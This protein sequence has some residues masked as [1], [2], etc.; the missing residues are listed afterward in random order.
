MHGGR[1][2]WE[3]MGSMGSTPQKQ[4]KRAPPTKRYV[5][6]VGVPTFS[7]S[8][9]FDLPMGIAKNVNDM[10]EHKR[11]RP[12]AG[13]IHGGKLKSEYKVLQ[14]NIAEE[15][16]QHPVICSSHSSGNA[17]EGCED[18]QQDSV[19]SSRRAAAWRR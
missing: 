13:L 11:V 2:Q 10:I 19:D 6:D 16:S 9:S 3:A 12:R 8:S 15:F 18:Y 4:A 1:K 5:G 7:E 17:P 14:H